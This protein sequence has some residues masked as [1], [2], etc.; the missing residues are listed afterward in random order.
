MRLNIAGDLALARLFDG[1]VLFGEELV[2]GAVEGLAGALFELFLVFLCLIGNLNS[3][4][5]GALLHLLGGFIFFEFH[6]VLLQLVLLMLLCISQSL[7]RLQVYLAQG[8]LVAFV[9]SIL[10][11]IPTF[12]ICVEC[13]HFV[14]GNSVVIAAR[15]LCLHDLVV[16]ILIHLRLTLVFSIGSGMSHWVFLLING[17]LWLAVKPKL[18][19]WF[20]IGIIVIMRTNILSHQISFIWLIVLVAL[21]DIINL[22]PRVITKV[23]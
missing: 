5:E 17:H 21:T 3:W 14:G 16:E 11:S 12:F 4:A 10:E 20:C 8:F 23:V 6:R 9:I 13:V 22:V 7:L 2:L 15:V 19:L 1:L 18:L